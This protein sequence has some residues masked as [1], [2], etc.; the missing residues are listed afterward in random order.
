[1]AKS[2]SAKQVLSIRHATLKMSGEW[3]N[4]VGEMD[5]HGVVFFWGNSGNGKTSAVVSFCKELCKYGQVLYVPLEEGF[6]L[7]MQNTLRRFGMQECGNRFQLLDK[8]SFEDLD[9]RLG[10]QRSPEFIV[11]DSFQ[12]TGMSYRD[13]IAFKEKYRNKLLIFVSHAN[14]HQPAGRPAT[15]VMYDAM[16]KIWV[17]GHVAQSKGRFMGRTQKAVIWRQG[18][19][20]YWGTDDFGEGELVRQ[21]IEKED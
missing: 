11:I 2:L 13:Y 3:E 5:R 7:S 21:Q 1:M 17:E 19:E 8:F 20:R 15:S 4:C 9:E 18:A 12:Y 6:S 16:L 10:K 14:G